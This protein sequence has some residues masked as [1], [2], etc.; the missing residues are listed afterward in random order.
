MID[1][2]S[3]SCAL[4]GVAFITPWTQGFFSISDSCNKKLYWLLHFSCIFLNWSVLCCIYFVRLPA[5]EVLQDLASD[6]ILFGIV[7]PNISW[8]VN[9]R[10]RGST[11]Q[12]DFKRFRK[13][14]IWMYLSLS[15]FWG[16]ERESVGVGRER[17]RNV[18]LFRV[19]S[20]DY[21]AFNVERIMMRKKKRVWFV[22]FRS[23]CVTLYYFQKL[24][25]FCLNLFLPCGHLGILLIVNHWNF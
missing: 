2:F 23:R 19:D 10:S 24:P 14:I 4:I 22:V 25:I 5:L 15:I 18:S 8:K 20:W 16:C 9:Q 11:E 7:F 6:E 21:W 3:I 13:G 17:D 12:S 1:F